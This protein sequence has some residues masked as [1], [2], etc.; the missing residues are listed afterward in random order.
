MSLNQFSGLTLLLDFR[1]RRLL[2]SWEY[3]RGSFFTVIFF[4]ETLKLCLGFLP[5]FPLDLLFVL[6]FFSIAFVEDTTIS[7]SQGIVVIHIKPSNIILFFLLFFCF[8]LF[9]TFFCFL[10]LLCLL[11]FSDHL[12]GEVGNLLVNVVGRTFSYLLHFLVCNKLLL[13]FIVL[14][15]LWRFN[16]LLSQ[17]N[18]VSF[19]ILCSFF[20]FIFLPLTRINFFHFDANVFVLIIFLRWPSFLPFQSVA[21]DHLYV[22]S[23]VV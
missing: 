11:F 18:S 17:S 9:L 19:L 2:K 13:L 15:F 6:S 14:L 4:D 23:N 8:W 5:A 3:V 21:F 20:F 10:L 16:R 12:L 1:L 7:V 22:T